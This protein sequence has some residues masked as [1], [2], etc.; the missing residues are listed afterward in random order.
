MP[1]PKVSVVITCYNYERYVGQAIASVIGQTHPAHELIVVNDGS[2]DGSEQVIRGF[3]QVKYIFQQNA[4]HVAGFN[5]GFAETSGEIVMFL[6]ADDLLETQAIEHVVRHWRDGCAKLQFDMTAI[7]GDGD[8]MG[9]RVCN[10]PHGYDEQVVRAEFARHGTYLWPVCSGNAYARAFLDQV[11][12]LA[13]RSAPDGYLNTIAPVYGAV[14]VVD[15]P[16]A[17]YRL[18]SQN[19]SYHGTDRNRLDLRFSKQIDLRT[20]E[21]AALRE[22]AAR[23]GV[24]LPHGNLLD[25]ELVFLN[26]RLMVK[27]MGG[28][29]ADDQA[30]SVFSLWRKAMSVVLRRPHKLSVRLANWTWLTALAVSPGPLAHALVNLRF[31][32]AEYLKRLRRRSPLSHA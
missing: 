26:Y 15:K 19:M 20:G 14:I 29:Y 7:D 28:R 31:N 9:R 12:P 2:T 10:F 17:R 21:F 23:L 32:R 5:R 24:P 8:S 27:K 22:H 16:L 11:M 3:P 13:V 30:D 1:E 25:T 4:G 18:H 6:D